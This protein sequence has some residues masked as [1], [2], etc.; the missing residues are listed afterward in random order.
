MTDKLTKVIDT[1][2]AE[3]EVVLR[4]KKGPLIVMYP[5]NGR[6]AEDFD[7]LAD[8]LYE[9]GW[10]SAAINPRGAAG[11][12][13]PLEGLTLHSYTGDIAAVIEALDGTPAAVLGH[14]FGN[15]VARCFAVDYPKMVRCLV[16]LA[17]GGKLPMAPE[18][19]EA[20]GKLRKG[21]SLEEI[22]AS[23]K[24]A[25]FAKGSNPDAWLT[26]VW[27]KSMKANR[28]AGKATPLK[29]WWSGGE[30][31]TLV[32]QGKEDRCALPE[33]GYLLKKEYGGRITVI[34]IDNAAHAL[35]PEQ[36]HAI[37]QAVIHYLKDYSEL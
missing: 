14:A 20:I 8:A 26:G 25:Y 35:L 10:R 6:G 2:A 3:I 5:G 36:P 23:F 34:D 33:N 16:L 17:A 21:L 19:I 13:G 9:A 4:G 7:H 22:R 37:A 29:A 32:I 18:V 30:A 31:P 1:G 12:K 15:R 28:I 27:P 24:T 11:S